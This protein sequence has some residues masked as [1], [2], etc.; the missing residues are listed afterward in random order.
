MG[1]TRILKTA[2]ATL[3]HTF[4]VDETGTDSSV[5][6]TVSVTDANGSSVAS[7]NATSAGAGR[8]TFALAGQSQT[9][10]LTAAWSG[11]ISGAAV[12]ETDSVEIVGGYFF[13]L[14]EG[15]NSDSTLA[16]SGKYPTSA[17]IEK[18][19]EVEVEC[20]E[21]CDRAFVPRYKRLVLDG[22]GNTELMLSGVNDV[23]S[24]RSVSMAPSIDGTFT[25]FTAGQLAKLAITP[26]RTLVRTDGNIW[27][28]ERSNVV[29]EL[30]YGFDSPPEDLK[31]AAKTRFRSRL[32]AAK[33]GIPERVMSYTTSDGSNYRLSIPDAYRTGIPDVDAAYGRWSLRS[34]V[35]STEDSRDVPASRLL[36]FDPQNYSLFHG[37]IR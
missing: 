2:A 29:V 33:S 35:G 1:L 30:E 4:Y 34:G 32:N 27:T 24:I 14:V 13:T 7:G 19:L 18:R 26:D 37:G 31:R 9:K 16:D 3:E 17:L 20:E 15:R 36:N 23:R 5:T 10:H 25:A 12:V 28:E 21:I 22:T 8:Y 6:V 11:T